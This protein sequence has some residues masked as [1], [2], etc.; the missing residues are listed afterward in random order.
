MNHR[1]AHIIFGVSFMF[2]SCDISLFF[3]FSMIILLVAAAIT[4]ARSYKIPNGI[5][6]ISIMIWIVIVT[7]I[8]I[9]DTAMGINK[10]KEGMAGFLSVGIVMLIAYLLVKRRLGAGDVKISAILGLYLSLDAALMIIFIAMLLSAV[11][12]PIL[13]KLH[14]DNTCAHVIKIPLAPFFLAGTL[15][16]SIDHIVTNSIILF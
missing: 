8:T 2:Y 1:L 6:K 3:Y 4:D 9:N 7:V 13:N 11:V 10:I 5:I 16:Y 12:Y 15:I 14:T